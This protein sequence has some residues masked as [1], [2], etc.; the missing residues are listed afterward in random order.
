M[1]PRLYDASAIAS[2]FVPGSGL[3]DFI[4][5]APA[6]G[7]GMG[8]SFMENMKKKQYVD[9]MLQMAGA[10][11]DAMMVVPP[12]GMTVKA[13]TTAGKTARALGNLPVKPSTDDA[14]QVMD[15]TFQYG[16]LGGKKTMPIDMLSGGVRM[17]DPKEAERVRKLAEQMSGPEGYISRLVVDDA[18]NVLEGQHRLAAMQMLGQKNVPVTVVKDLSRK[19][20][21]EAMEQALAGSM[22]RDQVKQMV[23]NAIEAL[24]DSG[25]VEKA[26]QEYVM[27]PKFQKQFESVLRAS[28]RKN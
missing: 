18:G 14:S 1:D 16:A 8:P 15:A 5:Q 20:N 4:G 2:G 11:G 6:I 22:R 25:S 28:Q 27:P 17:N 19:Y 23:Q 21:T 3:M 9:A 12:V 26:L 24:E 10:A 7:G 13:A